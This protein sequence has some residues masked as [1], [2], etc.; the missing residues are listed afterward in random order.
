[1]A[2]VLRSTDR[3][4]RKPSSNNFC[5]QNSVIRPES[6]LVAFSAKVVRIDGQM[7]RWTDR[8]MDRPLIQRS[9]PSC[10]TPKRTKKKKKKKKQKN[11][12]P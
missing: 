9:L 3:Q 10:D 12:E 2:M 1:M 6:R 5:I 7:D 4:T 8:Q 11:P